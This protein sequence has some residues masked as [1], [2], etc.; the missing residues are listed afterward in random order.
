MVN[1]ESK[2]IQHIGIIAGMCNEVDLIGKIDKRVTQK[3]RKVSVGEA[4][5]AMILNALGLSG[6]AMYLTPRYYENRP[7]GTL[8]G[9]DLKARDLH[10]ASLGTALD[11]IYDY[12]ITELFFEVSSQILKQQGIDTK[13]AHLDSTTFSLHG[14]YNSEDETIEEG[15]IHITKGYSKDNA[16]ELNQVV[17]QMISANNTSIPVWIEALSG[18]SSDKASFKETVKAFQD[19]FDQSQ[20][21]Y[22][23]MDSAFYSKK[24]LME[25]KDFRWVTRVPETLKEV[26]ERYESINR[27]TM[28]P[29]GGGYSYLPV[30]SN[31]AEIQQRWLVIYSQKAFEREIKTFEKN[32]IKQRQRKEKDLKHLR[33][34]PFACKKDA[35]TAADQFNKKMVYFNFKYTLTP[36][37]CFKSKGRP[38]KD[39]EPEH[40][41]WYISGTISEDEGSIEKARL[42]KGMFVVATNELDT[43]LLSDL[44]VFEAY[45]DQNISVERGF[46]FLKDPVFYAE[47]LYLKK[48]KRIMALIM[49]MTLSLLIYSLAERKIRNTLK[50]QNQYIWDQKKKRTNNPTARWVFMIFEDVLLLYTRKGRRIVGCQAMNL[51]QEHRIILRCLGPAYEKMYFLE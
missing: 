29:L 38:K 14:E 26:G 5:Q 18:N 7:V 41:E 32:L 40:I 21:P 39:S 8:V 11:A 1:H 16:P 37:K 45:K 19:Q 43:Q 24:S 51:R 30:S 20:M 13:F 3:R 28:H 47:S 31:Y 36:V 27:E 22:M 23:V 17:A 6:R 48:P 10:D 42:K 35:Q 50:E 34:K 33:N 46:R 9:S 44:E 2:L 15:V 25:C 12:G 4:V 49:V